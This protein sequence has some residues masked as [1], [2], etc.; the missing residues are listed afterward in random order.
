ME[1]FYLAC[2]VICGAAMVLCVGQL[3][4]WWVEDTFFGGK[5]IL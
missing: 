3:I 4:L 5:T 2:L 1:W